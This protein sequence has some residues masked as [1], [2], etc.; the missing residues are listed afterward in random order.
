MCQGIIPSAQPSGYCKSR[1]YSV[2]VRDVKIILIFWR[3]FIERICSVVSN[4]SIW[5]SHACNMRQCAS[6]NEVPGGGINSLPQI[7]FIVEVEGRD[8]AMQCL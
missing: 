7:P 6:C 3:V 8:V 1:C 4:L 5:M 2:R